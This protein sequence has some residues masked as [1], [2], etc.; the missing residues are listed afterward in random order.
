MAGDGKVII[1]TLLNSDGFKNGLSKLGSIASTGIK[2][3]TTA[4]AA[5]G[6]AL[7]GLG[8]YAVKVGS[9]FKSTMS[10][11][12]AVSG[13]S[14][15]QVILA[16][17]EAVNGL[18]AISDIAKEMGATTKFSATES[19]EALT[20]MGMA[21]WNAQQMYD[22]LPG[23]L[24]LAAASGEDLATTSDIVTDAM[25][26]FGMEAKEAGHFADILAKTS[27]SA[28]TNVSILGESFKYAAPI[29]G[30]MGY[31]AEDAAVALGLMANAGIKGSQAGTTLKNA[32][33]RLADPKTDAAR[34]A[35]QSLGL[36][37]EDSEGK[38]KSLMEIMTD[39]RKGLNGVDISVTDSEGNIKDYDQIIN[40][41]SQSEDGLSK[42]QK[43]Q[44]AAT[45]FGTEAMAGMLA[46]TNSSDEDFAKLATEIYNC[47]GAAEEMRLIMEDNLQGDM[48]KLSSATEGLG[49]AVYEHMDKPLRS[50]VQSATNYIDRLKSAFDKGGFKGLV[51]EIGTVISDIA[52]QIV[53]AAPTL[54]EA[55]MSLIN[56]FV[57]GI[58]SA[59]PQ[60]ATA[61]ANILVTFVQ[62]IGQLFPKLVTL[63]I[64]VI[65]NLMQG[66]TQSAP[67]LTKA[68]GGGLAATLGAIANNLPEFLSAGTDMIIALAE[69][70]IQQLP[71]IG[72]A[73]LNIINSLVGGVASN[74]PRLLQSGLQ[75]LVQLSAGIS[76]A[77]PTL[78]NIA[79]MVI[80]NFVD[81]IVQSL[82][83]LLDAG[84]EIITN[85]ILGIT[86]VIPTI[87]E[88]A[89]DIV[90]TLIEGL[91]SADFL[92]SATN[93]ISSLAT[94]LTE[95]IPTIAET[96]ITIVEGLATSIVENGPALMETAVTLINS[97]LEGIGQVLP[98]LAVAA[99]NIITSLS[100]YLIENAPQIITAAIFMIAQ[101][102]IGILQAIGN[103]YTSM[104]EIRR[105]IL[106]AIINI[107]IVQT[108]IELIKNLASGI[109]NA[110]SSVITSAKTVATNA[111]NTIQNEGWLALGM[112]VL[113]FVANG[114]I[115]AV[116][117]IITSAKTAAT[118]ALNTIKNTDWRGLGRQIL[119]FVA[120]GITGAVGSIIGAAR[121]AASSAMSAFKGLSWSSV[122]SHIISGISGGI[123][124]AVRSLASS[125]AS[126]AQ[127]ALNAAKNALG[128]KSP[129]RKFRDE[130]GRWI[131]PGVEVGIEETQGHLNDT[132][133]D[134]S[135]SML[136]AFNIPNE[137]DSV[138][139]VEKMK[140]V[141]VS[142][143]EST[144]RGVDAKANSGSGQV[145]STESEKMDYDR[146]G[147]SVAGALGRAGIKVELNERELGR[148]ITP[149]V[150][151]LA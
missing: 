2:A 111:K 89:L 13:A 37:M 91:A 121:S 132:M 46:I 88:C 94:G 147:N 109:I 64:S 116:S 150:T 62:G 8:G 54:I 20:Y 33:T 86:E 56:S 75:M 49:V 1:D 50:V 15:Q 119:S 73:A 23:I 141:V 124:G 68:V 42:V 52:T 60:I 84:A 74:A 122:G 151:S 143:M 79:T 5:A 137:A 115:G 18:T 4:V 135:E 92:E 44:A 45:I 90:T 65:T 114:I 107:P 69:G 28:N 9:S 133:A 22:G 100:G 19:A 70:L 129:S 126:A 139:L 27:S 36:S 110:V 144:T 32:I 136:N 41:L 148:L 83:D 55:A 106:Q 31:K 128:I 72:Q 67:E 63:G 103:I 26:A 21:G 7:V 3:T 6:T 113:R 98:E 102:G 16:S 149:I 17:G 71:T 38:T 104:G 123:T 11:V 93:L 30:T 66:I 146:I 105:Q 96:A 80:T 97:L 112:K 145:E 51:S 138:G 87:G 47:N 76:Q 85:L 130:V 29:C 101:L 57:E 134:A 59:A 39:L 10:E 127:S 117:S 95:A 14:S 43:V 125:A 108:G 120:N 77:L 34:E 40:E 53:D 58:V 61:A 24:N 35:M 78:V 99:V 25:T 48:D 12:E 82:P 118:N 142:T 131:L 140:R 81:Y